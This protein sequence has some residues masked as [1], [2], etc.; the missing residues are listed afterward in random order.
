LVNCMTSVFAST[1]RSREANLAL[2]KDSKMLELLSH[3]LN[4]E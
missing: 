1:A 2:M 4:H 3:L